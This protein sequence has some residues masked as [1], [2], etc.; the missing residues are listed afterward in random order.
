MHEQG[1]ELRLEAPHYDIVL[2]T[3]LIPGLE[4]ASLV[5]LGVGN[6]GRVNADTNDLHA[7][8]MRRHCR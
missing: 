3:V 1:G 8:I 7:G 6:K 2:P 5:H 4:A